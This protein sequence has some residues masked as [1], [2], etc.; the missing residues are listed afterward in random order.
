MRQ[1]HAIKDHSPYL[2][3][4]S[5]ST[6]EAQMNSC[7]FSQKSYYSVHRGEILIMWIFE[8]ANYD[9]LWVSL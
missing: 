6:V 7:I 1:N 3:Q 8:A 9:V 5:L 4:I 2:D